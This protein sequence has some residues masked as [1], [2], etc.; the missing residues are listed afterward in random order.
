MARPKKIRRQTP[1][2]C[3]WIA[4][5]GAFGRHYYS[6][7]FHLVARCRD[8]KG[9]DTFSFW[10]SAGY[11]HHIEACLQGRKYMVRKQ[12][13]WK[14]TQA[15]R[16]GL[17]SEQARLLNVFA[18]CCVLEQKKGKKEFWKQQTWATCW[19]N[20]QNLAPLKILCLLCAWAANFNFVLGASSHLWK[21]NSN[22]LLREA[23]GFQESRVL[24]CAR[25][26]LLVI[27]SNMFLGCNSNKGSEHTPV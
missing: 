8:G 14:H 25:V 23:L 4:K 26:Y 16:I 15:F 3:T 7:L 5:V 19:V 6:D 22:L 24:G 18:S 17:P 1:C 20:I 10:S 27:R 9:R 11:V 13:Q 12:E 2:M 21:S